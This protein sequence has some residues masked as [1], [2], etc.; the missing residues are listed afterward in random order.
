MADDEDSR[1]IPM[2]P[3]GR[4]DAA[5]RRIAQSVTDLA[6]GLRLAE[7]RQQKK[8]SELTGLILSLLPAPQAARE[9]KDSGD[10]HTDRFRVPTLPGVDVGLTRKAQ[11]EL[12]ARVGRFVFYALAFILSH[13]AMYFY[14]PRPEAPA[15]AHPA[16]ATLPPATPP[17]LP[18][19]TIQVPALAPPP[20]HP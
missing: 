11:R 3:E 6:E 9:R 13:I 18:A 7:Q 16:P 4:R 10:E 20:A 14:A 17:A 2:T 5:L 12:I 8:D 1:P 19:P 15:V